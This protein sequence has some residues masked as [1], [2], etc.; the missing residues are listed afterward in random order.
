MRGNDISEFTSPL[1]L[2][3]TSDRNSRGYQTIGIGDG[4]NEIGMGKLD[5]TIVAGS[6][7]NGDEIAC[8]VTCDYLLVCGVSNWGGM[9]LVAALAT[10]MP[11][12]REK[13]LRNMTVERDLEILQAVVAKGRGV[14]GVLGKREL[15]V[16]GLPAKIH[17]NVLRSILRQL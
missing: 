11:E 10:L 1:H 7:E 4:G 17:S 6:I 8:G 16:D 13:L 5:P 14:D 3:F 15:S 12:L 9:G 2:L